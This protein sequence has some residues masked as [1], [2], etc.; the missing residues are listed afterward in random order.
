MQSWVAREEHFQPVGAGPR[1][2]AQVTVLERERATLAL[3]TTRTTDPLPLVRVDHSVTP[4]ELRT[5][6]LP[7]VCIVAVLPAPVVKA[8]QWRTPAAE[9]ST[10]LPSVRIVSSHALLVDRID[11]PERSTWPGSIRS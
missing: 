8:A 7:S 10:R 11:S 3:P 4:L 9:V 2:M 6:K 5:T 1:V